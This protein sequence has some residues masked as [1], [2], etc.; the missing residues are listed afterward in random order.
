MATAA[1]F[2]ETF[3]SDL[4]N[5]PADFNANWLVSDGSPSPGCARLLSGGGAILAEPGDFYIVTPTEFSLL[6][7][8]AYKVLN[9]STAS[10]GDA[11]TLLV[12]VNLGSSS[13]GFN[14]VTWLLAEADVS[15]DDTG[16]INATFDLSDQWGGIP[17]QA[18]IDF[19]KFT[20]G[21]GGGDPYTVYIDSVEVTS[22]V[23][24]SASKF[25]FGQGPGAGVL[26][27]KFTLPFNDV[28]PQAMSLSGILGTVVIG[29]KVG[30]GSPTGS[31]VI[32]SDYPYSGWTN[33]S[34]GFPTGTAIS[35]LKWV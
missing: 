21:A 34:S 11:I 13:A 23:G 18:A 17:G 12:S 29:S 5:Y 33:T 22:P 8:F 9:G 15:T 16:W 25:Y 31:P 6:V 20:S 26:A 7:N 10:G 35:A 24:S 27:E 30:A 28:S 19:V 1:D 14:D 32:Y 2:S 3:D 4:G